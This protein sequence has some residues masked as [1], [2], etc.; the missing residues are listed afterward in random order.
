[1]TPRP[2]CAARVCAPTI[3]RPTAIF[4][5]GSA[6]QRG[7]AALALAPFVPVVG[8]GITPLQPVHVDDVARA[9]AD[10]VDAD[11]FAGESMNLGG[12]EPIAVEALLVRLRQA[13]GRDPAPSC[14]CRRGSC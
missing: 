2:S 5:P 13:A 14:T 3:V 4:G 1:M 7:L 8:A 11:R 10:L 6:V 12:P 9:L